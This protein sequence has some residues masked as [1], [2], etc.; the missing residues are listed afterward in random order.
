[1][2]GWLFYIQQIARNKNSSYTCKYMVVCRYTRKGFGYLVTY[3]LKR[4]TKFVET[5]KP[6]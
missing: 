3:I 1:M 6:I 4:W 2:A 5:T